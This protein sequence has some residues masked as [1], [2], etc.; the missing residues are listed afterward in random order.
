MQELVQQLFGE[1]RSALRFRWHGMALAWIG[2]IVGWAVVALLPD[3]YEASAR[4]FVDTKSVLEPVLR[5]QMARQDVQGELL[6]VREALTGQQLLQRVIDE[7][8]LAPDAT[9]AERNAMVAALRQRITVATTV[10]TRNNEPSNLFNISYRHRDRQKAVAVV[11]ALLNAFIE[12]THEATRAGSATA[13]RFLDERVAEYEQRLQEAERAR[14]EFKRANAARLPGVEGDYF[15]R[16]QAENE[17]LAQARRDLRVL[18]LKREQLARQLTSEVAVVSGMDAALDKLPPNSIDARIRDYQAQLDAKLL[19][20]TERHPDIIALREALA[21]LQRQRQEQLQAL[22]FEGEAELAGLGANPVYQALQISMN[23]TDVELA[24]L[25]ADIE[26]R[27][28]KMHEL[29][30]LIDEVPKVEAELA[31]LNRDYDVIFEQ[32]EEL[33]RSRETQGI[34]RAASDTDEVDFRVINPPLAAPDPVAP[35]RLPLFSF[36]LLGALAAGG[37]LC[38]VLAQL[39]PV[40]T[41]TKSLNVATGLPVLGTVTHA[42][43]DTAREERRKAVWAYSLA[44]LSLLTLYLGV[45]AI[46]VLNVIPSAGQG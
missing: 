8:E 25:R 12:D 32:Y 22:G 4:V 1:L 6:Y 9:E 40:F 16:M 11:D 10:P 24:T 31:R 17:Q 23:E 28:V 35:V 41:G 26:D 18:E 7:A 38:Y 45:L 5:N 3:V 46:E 13:E 27:R 30:G 42:W 19:D 36:V 34:T 21:Q 33:V 2:C 39:H 44:F 37:L 43:D 29:Q 15:T 14:A 20:Y